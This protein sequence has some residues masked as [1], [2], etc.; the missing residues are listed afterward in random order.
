MDIDHRPAVIWFTTEEPIRRRIYTEKLGIDPAQ[1]REDRMAADPIMAALGVPA[2]PPDDSSSL[3]A[4][5]HYWGTNVVDTELLAAQDMRTRRK[6]RIS[7]DIWSETFSAVHGP[8]PV[9]AIIKWEGGRTV[10]SW[11][12]PTGMEHPDRRPSGTWNYQEFND[13]LMAFRTM[14]VE[15]IDA[16]AA[17]ETE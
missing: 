9:N 3:E 8:D 6:V 13:S 5:L 1:G 11:F 4:A 10:S 12:R 17:R 14:M 7:K 16:V 2:H 15:K